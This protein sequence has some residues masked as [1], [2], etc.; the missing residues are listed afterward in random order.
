M[1]HLVEKIFTGHPVFMK[2][3]PKICNFKVGRKTEIFR[4]ID[5][6]VFNG[7]SLQISM[8]RNEF[9]KVTNLRNILKQ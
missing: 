4:K 7:E 5:V 3:S 2:L 8:A 9:L 6:R 1:A